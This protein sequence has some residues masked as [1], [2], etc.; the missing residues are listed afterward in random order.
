MIGDQM[1]FQ[2]A[3]DI[4]T[5]WRVV[6]PILKAWS[7]ADGSDLCTY[8]AGSNGPEAAERLLTY[9]GQHWRPIA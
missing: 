7:E 5:G 1:L 8:P 6:D 9:G 4:E 2:R 3:I